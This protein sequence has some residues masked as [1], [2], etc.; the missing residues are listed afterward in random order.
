MSYLVNLSLADKKVV[1]IGGGRI[2]ARKV[3]RLTELDDI[4]DILVIS[5]CFCSD[6]PEHFKI[7]KKQRDYQKNDLKGAHLIF[8]C[9]NDQE[10]NQRITN[11]AE[12]YQWV[13]DVSSPANSDF[14]NTGL[15][16]TGD[17]T[18]GISHRLKDPRATKTF[19]EDLEKHFL[20]K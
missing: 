13:N 3:R 10:I 17:F 20:S 12:Y 16:K 14:T 11:D 1:V 9:T 8:A 5:P 4:P 7:E 6:F 15:V 18:L 2:A 19:C